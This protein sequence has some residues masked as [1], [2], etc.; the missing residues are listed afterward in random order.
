M[1]GS[2]SE[3]MARSERGCLED[4]E[5]AAFAEGRGS[6]VARAEAEV[7]LARCPECYELFVAVARSL[8]ED[9]PALVAPASAPARFRPFALAAGLAAAILAGV[10]SQVRAP[11]RP[12]AGDPVREFPDRSRS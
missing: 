10:W 12:A 5:L 1:K 4:G 9:G 7:H 6:A 3:A 8:A 11:E 2:E